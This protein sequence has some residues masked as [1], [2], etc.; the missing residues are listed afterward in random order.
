MSI[1]GIV[2]SM[3]VVWLIAAILFAIIEA[4]TMGLATIWFAG[5]AIA[6][7]LLALLNLNVGIQI[8]AFLVV[9]IVLLVFTR[10]LFVGKL[11]TGDVKTNVD[12]LIGERAVV[13]TE[14]KPLSTGIIRVGGQ[15]WTAVSENDD[16]IIAAGETVVIIEIHGVKAVVKKEK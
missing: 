3:A 15:E 13:T 2:I 5:G 11:K 4:L 6:A 16:E 9:S 12:A 14:I 7:M 8:A 10:K 1:G